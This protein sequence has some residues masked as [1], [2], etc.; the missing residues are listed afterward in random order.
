MKKSGIFW[1]IAM[2]LAFATF[3][4]GFYLGK[5]WSR[6]DVEISVSTAEGSNTDASNMTNISS[7][8][9]QININTA[10]KAQLMNLPGIGAALA[11]RIID[12]RTLHGN[13]KNVS[14]LAAVEG[15]GADT[16]AELLPYITIGG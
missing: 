12:Y 15:I 8:V 10:T 11:Q 14:E 6:S 2:T 1:L 7:G 13:F 9:K 5:N 3:V 4:A 16:L